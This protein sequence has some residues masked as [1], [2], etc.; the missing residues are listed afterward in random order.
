MMP[1]GAAGACRVFRLWAGWVA[2]SGDLEAE[3]AQHPGRAMD[4][5]A[6][7]MRADPHAGRERV[8]HAEDRLGIVAAPAVDQQVR[9]RPAEPVLGEELFLA[10]PVVLPDRPYHIHG[11]HPR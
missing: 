9:R 11:G 5:A 6:E 7:I 8:G 3:P 2:C 1:D 10:H 4:T